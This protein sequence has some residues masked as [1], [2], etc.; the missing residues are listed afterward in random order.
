VGESPE[1]A[2]VAAAETDPVPAPE[3]EDHSVEIHKP[4][5]PHSWREFLSEIGIIVIGVLL[6]LS[7]E[8]LVETWHWSHQE[9]AERTALNNEAQYFLGAAKVQVRQ[10]ACLLRELRDL[11]IV[12]ER[13]AHGRPLGLSRPVT[14]PYVLVATRGTWHIALAGQALSHMPLSEQL[15]YGAAFESYDN[16]NRIGDEEADAWARLQLLNHP[17]IM[18]DQD[19]SVVHQAYVAAL[20]KTKSAGAFA[21]TVLANYN[22]G[23]RPTAP[24]DDFPAGLETACQPLIAA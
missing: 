10:Q 8:Q 17:E 14:L 9:D 12:L 13:H 6:A 24:P 11:E 20:G 16:L 15:A 18:N 19:W 1:I 23:L 2:P 21:A 4:K 7:G 3:P 5:A 22:L